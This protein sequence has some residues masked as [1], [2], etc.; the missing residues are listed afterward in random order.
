MPERG[1]F[2]VFEGGEGAGKSTQVRMLADRLAESGYDVLTT[3]EPGGT[4]TAEAIR[5]LLL[6]PAAEPMS[7]RCEALLFAAARAD[8]VAK[9]IEPALDSGRIVVCDRFVDSSLAYQGSARGLAVAEVA[10]VSR[11]ATAGLVPDLTVLLDIPPARGLARA[12]DGNRMESQS[13]AFHDQVRAG[14]LALASAE[15]HRYLVVAAD[16]TRE[17]IG[18]A[19]WEVI[20]ERLPEPH[21]EGLR[22]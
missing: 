13:A 1:R 20:R 3:R 9:V 15:P 16:S 5:E 12:V 4:P 2:V 7:D 19:V 18:A 6:A 17:E 8:H 22:R 14:L 10:E 11:W 21:H